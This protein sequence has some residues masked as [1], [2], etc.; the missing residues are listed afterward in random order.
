M[1]N[2]VKLE[3]ATLEVSGKNY[4]PW[5]I[6]VKMHLESKGI[7]NAIHEFNNC[8][9]QDK[10]K[11][12]VFLRK[13]IEEMLR[14]EYLDITDPSVLWN[15]LKERFG[16]QKEV[17]LPNARDE[18]RTLRFQ[19]FKKVNDTTQLCSE[20]VHNSSIVDKKLLMKI[21]WRKCTPHFMQQTLP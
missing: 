4:V 9:A 2:V 21:C 7:S 11:A 12:Q 8:L 17:I 13:H 3:F 5:M 15:L 10:A 16:H 14:F 6:D 1:S 18:W 19:D 20:Y